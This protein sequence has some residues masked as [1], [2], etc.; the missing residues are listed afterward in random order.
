MHIKKSRQVPGDDF[1]NLAWAQLPDSHRVLMLALR[2]LADVGGANQL[3]LHRI[4]RET[5]QAGAEGASWPTIDEVETYMLELA[6]AGFLIFYQDPKGSGTELWKIAG[7]WPPPQKQGYPVWEPP[8]DAAEIR[9]SPPP[10]L[11]FRKPV[12]GGERAGGSASERAGA[13]EGSSGTPQIPQLRMSPS[14]F[15]P[16]HPGGPPPKLDCRDCGTA[17]GRQEEHREARVALKQAQQLPPLL[18]APV[19]ERLEAKIAELEEAAAR[20]ALGLHEPEADQVEYIT[21]DGL[22]ETT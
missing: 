19:V 1:T 15:C 4:R 17:R 16:D 12:V 11:V 22:I 13:G 14:R 6:E 8:P 5:W 21:D 7:K 20:D 2:L 3:D 10:N 18:R 9:P